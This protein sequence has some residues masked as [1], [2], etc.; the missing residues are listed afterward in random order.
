MSQGPGL[1][2]PLPSPH[3]DAPSSLVGWVVAPPPCGPVWG[4]GLGHE[5]DAECIE[6]ML[7]GCPNIC[8]CDL[9]SNNPANIRFLG[10][11]MPSHYV[12]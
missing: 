3:G 1:T 7:P 4:G 8:L 2:P 10:N 11:F 12:S 9:C 6:R 5:M